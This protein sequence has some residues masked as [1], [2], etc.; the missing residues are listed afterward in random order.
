MKMK[1]FLAA[2]FCLMA[3]TVFGAVPS[4]DKFVGAG[5]VVVTANPPTG[6]IIIDGSGVIASGTNSTIRVSVNGVPLL[7]AATNI[8]LIAGTNIV[9]TSVTATNTAHITINSRDG[10]VSTN[11]YITNHCFVYAEGD[12]N[13]IIVTGA[14]TPAANG[15]YRWDGARWTNASSAVHNITL[16]SDTY[17]LS[18]ATQLLYENST[19]RPVAPATQWD[20]FSGG[21]PAPTAVYMD[22]TNCFDFIGFSKPPEFPPVSTNLYLSMTGN[23]TN[24][25]R[26]RIE[27]PWRNIYKAIRDAVPGDTLVIGPGIYPVDPNLLNE[28]NSV[29]D[30]QGFKPLNFIGAG[31]EVTI[32]GDPSFPVGEQILHVSSNT[33]IANLTINGYVRIGRQGSVCSNVTFQSCYI[34]GQADS[35]YFVSWSGGVSVYNSHLKS[36]YDNVAD[37]EVLPMVNS[38][39]IFRAFNTFMETDGHAG[40]ARNLS[41]NQSRY[42]FYGCYLLTR[43]GSLGTNGNI[44]LSHEAGIRTNDN[45]SVLLSG[46]FL[47][48]SHNAG[49]SYAIYNIDPTP[50]ISIV[51]PII[52]TNEVLNCASLELIGDW[53]TKRGVTNAAKTAVTVAAGFG[54]TV[55][56]NETDA[57]ITY[58]IGSTGGGGGGAGTNINQF[59]AAG[60][61]LTI[62]NTPFFTNIVNRGFFESLND[63]DTGTTT[64][65]FYIDSVRAAFYPHASGSGI[66]RIGKQGGKSWT[67]DSVGAAMQMV[68][69][70]GNVQY[71]V[72][73]GNQTNSGWINT[74]GGITNY[75][76]GQSAGYTPLNV[77][78]S[79]AAVIGADG[80]ITNAAG[81]PD[82]TKFLRDDNTYAVP[83][84]TNTLYQINGVNLGS[85]GTI[86]WTA[87][88]TGAVI[89]GVAVLGVTASGS[90][91]S[92]VTTNANQFGP[93]APGA[94]MIIVKS[95]ALFTN[96]TVYTAFNVI[97]DTAL[98]GALDVTGTSSLKDT[99]L[100][101]TGTLTIDEAGAVIHGTNTVD[102][103]A[104]T[105]GAAAGY[106]MVCAVGNANGYGIWTNVLSISTLNVNT[107]NITSVIASTS[108]GAA[109]NAGDVQ[110]KEGATFAGTNQ[111]NFDRTNQVLRVS[112]AALNTIVVSNAARF[113]GAVTNSGTVTNA[114]QVYTGGNTTNHGAADFKSTVTV[115][116]LT[117]SNLVMSGPSKILTSIPNGTG[118]LTNGGGGLMGWMAIPSG[119]G[120]T[121][122]GPDGAIQFAQGGNFA[123]TN[124]LSVTT[125]SWNVNMRGLILTNRIALGFV[126]FVN[127]DPDFGTYGTN[128]SFFLISNTTQSSVSCYLH[129]PSN[130]PGQ[131][132][133]IK[134][135]AG[136]AATKTIQFY[137]A[138]QG[139]LLDGQQ[140]AGAIGVPFINANYG[141]AILFS[142]GHNWW[143]N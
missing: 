57:N 127:T 33:I 90:G 20:T 26:G 130:M 100:M 41:G 40:P 21:L 3:V 5:G 72:Q 97:G 73:S 9:L 105:N 139:F 103:L 81:T 74:A 22:L 55:T 51:G 140:E 94:A 56:T 134:D 142:D 91:S 59:G 106:V 64:T 7:S 36:G 99:H 126:T 119:G 141:S 25:Q 128:T 120:G 62:K 82:G 78:A 31:A 67:Y 88:V 2:F 1:S 110:F 23:D 6:N 136:T 109:G 14:G 4:Y 122:F 29:N 83:T 12:T 17:G 123:G 27:Y 65:N 138:G 63:P 32:L 98:D 102:R 70:A 114:G 116:T 8:D 89:S 54:A 44:F 107:L 143:K 39:R 52:N 24:A 86:N 46:C 132:I 42:E 96:T 113:L 79:R 66:V 16:I 18:N 19:G 124:T 53:L 101:G 87:G 135:I 121:A 111:F 93:A 77:T 28:F 92:G 104:M 137:N 45:G 125:N 118:M 60:A 43:N 76:W 35:I 69:T 38:N 117:A 13:N 47:E 34:N 112:N 10:G 129:S 108:L 30:P 84:G 133:F 85:A 95:G 58:T 15:V 61:I 80:T 131:V 48:H 37:Y 71:Q 49:A 50:V 115:Q 68:S 11:L 75:G